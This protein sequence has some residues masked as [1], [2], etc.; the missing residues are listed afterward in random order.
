MPRANIGFP[1]PNISSGMHREFKKSTTKDMMGWCS[2]DSEQYSNSDV[3]DSTAERLNILM[4]CVEK[5]KIDKWKTESK[6]EKL[7]IKFS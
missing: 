3:Q 4:G 2:N 7:R 5:R 1:L 6:D